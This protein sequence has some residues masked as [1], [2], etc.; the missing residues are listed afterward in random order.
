[1]IKL[2]QC[3][4]CGGEAKIKTKYLANKA[5]VYVECVQCGGSTGMYAIDAL[6]MPRRLDPS[7]PILSNVVRAWNTRAKEPAREALKEVGP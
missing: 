2:R 7:D 4:F 3:P 6:R 1:M 5:I